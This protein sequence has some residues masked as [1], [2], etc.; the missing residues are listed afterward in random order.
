VF[1]IAFV[2][3]GTTNPVKLQNIAVT[4]ED[5]DNNQYVEFFGL[6][7]Y[8]L[9]N[10]RVTD[11]LDAYTGSTTLTLM[12][13]ATVSA[14]VPDGA[15]RFFARGDSSDHNEE[16]LVV[17]AKF[18]ELSTLRTKLGVYE[19]GSASMDLSFQTFSFTDAA[20]PT[21]VVQPSFS[22]SY[23]ENEGIG[24]APDST[25]A[26][27]SQSVLG[28]SGL[29]PLTREG[30]TFRGWNTRADGTGVTYTE[31]DSIIPIADTT[32]YALWRSDAELAN[33]GFD[34]DSLVM[35]A[36]AIGAGA[37]LMVLR[38]SRRSPKHRA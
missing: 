3:S 25:T 19:N 7:S 14:T 29:T 21:T 22:V 13:G 24:A 20:A 38:G 32:L 28:N 35:G 5:V 15:V 31:G 36:T 9:S 30:Y 37:L 16:H 23:N 26:A 18:A 17:E 6:T 33:T 27:G 4:V 12:D 2:A 1:D 8:V 11:T 10:G 34:E